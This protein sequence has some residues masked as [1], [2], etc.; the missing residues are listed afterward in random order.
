[1]QPSTEKCPHCGLIHDTTC[2]RIKSIDYYKDGS[3]KR[4]EFHL[5]TPISSTVSPPPPS[6]PPPPPLPTPYDHCR[7][8]NGHFK[9]LSATEAKVLELLAKGD[10]NKL[11]AIKM[12][13][14]E[15]TVKVHVKSIL[16]KLG[17]RNRTQA[18][19]F[20]STTMVDNS[21][22]SVQHNMSNEGTGNEQ[23]SLRA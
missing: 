16:R 13:N 3:V 17:V 5:P 8:P 4:I 18:A 20:F 2:P 10:S 7:R 19:T 14:C 12:G 21:L 9:G 11:V 22:L 1:M 6:P 23:I 15:A